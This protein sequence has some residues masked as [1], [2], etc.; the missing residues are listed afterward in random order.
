MCA[1]R[2]RHQPILRVH[3]DRDGVTSA[4]KRG[5]LRLV[6]ECTYRVIPRVI[7]LLRT[8]LLE[9]G[10]EAHKDGICSG[11]LHSIRLLPDCIEAIFDARHGILRLPIVMQP[12]DTHV[13]A[14]DPPQSAAIDDSPTVM[15]PVVCLEDAPQ[16]ARAEFIPPALGHCALIDTMFRVMDEVR[17]QWRAVGIRKRWEELTDIVA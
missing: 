7:P 15:T 5:G 9:G 16:V 14:H 12:D 2:V 3:D 1:G 10:L 17:V 6:S 11:G 8:Q 13:I 4:G